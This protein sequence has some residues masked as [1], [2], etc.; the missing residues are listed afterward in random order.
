MLSEKDRSQ[1]FEPFRPHKT[2]ADNADSS[3]SK[4]QLD[5]ETPSKV[6]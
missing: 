6:E 5:G 4:E 3:H 1:P 2:K